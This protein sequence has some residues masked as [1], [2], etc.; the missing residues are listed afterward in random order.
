MP[1]LPCNPLICVF[2]LILQHSSSA[3]HQ[4]PSRPSHVSRTMNINITH[5]SCGA[6]SAN[7]SL[8]ITARTQSPQNPAPQTH[9][10]IQPLL[11]CGRAKRKQAH[12]RRSNCP[13][14]RT[15]PARDVTR[16]KSTTTALNAASSIQKR[17]GARRVSKSKNLRVSVRSEQKFRHA[18][19]RHPVRCS[20]HSL[21][22]TAATQQ[23]QQACGLRQRTSTTRPFRY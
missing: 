19:G 3:T 8:H 6:S 14:S 5:I 20:C 17:E 16:H 13:R 11:T 9:V 4:H 7:T 22:R 18:G 10:C 2:L 12:A 23:H 1:A 15:P 21:H